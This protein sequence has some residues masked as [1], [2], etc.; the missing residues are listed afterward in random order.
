MKHTLWLLPV[1]LLSGCYEPIDAT[2]DDNGSSSQQTSGGDCQLQVAVLSS[3]AEVQYPVNLLVF[4][5]EGRRMDDCAL[6]EQQPTA[7]LSLSRGSYRLVALSGTSCY[8]LPAS[9]NLDSEITYSSQYLPEQP[10][11]MGEA[12]VTL[13]S[14]SA[15]ACLQMVPQTAE[16]YVAATG[17]PYNTRQVQL[18]ISSLYTSVSMQGSFGQPQSQNFTC[19]KAGS[20]W[21][22]GPY[23][24]F[25]AYGTN[26]VVSMEV[27]RTDSTLYYGYTL[28]YPILAGYSYELAP[29][30]TGLVANGELVDA[31]S[32]SAS[33]KDDTLT[34]DAM[35]VAPCLWDGHVVAYME[36]NDENE[37]DLWLLSF[38]EWEDIHSANSELYAT[39][40]TDIASAYQEGGTLSGRLTQWHIPTKEEAYALRSLY[41]GDVRINIL[42]QVLQ[43]SGLP[44]WTIADASGDNVRYLCNEAQHTFTLASS[45]SSITKG[46]TKATYR[47]RLLKKLHIR[48][49]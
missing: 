34:L 3:S 29:S 2:D 26:T 17:L 32:A 8:L 21:M 25:P 46:G 23:C 1:L 18:T 42:N 38:N 12:D 22:A 36:Q 14:A 10:L 19:T 5:A 45:S 15:K 7:T 30:P 31:S 48:T 6:T 39:E 41:S 4:D 13:A 24:L 40:A 28:P 37:A 20:R 44:V 16:V 49:K 9:Y 33:A 43:L 35:P 47:L 11:M 27:V